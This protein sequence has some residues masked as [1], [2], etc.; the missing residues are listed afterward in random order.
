MRI[1]KKESGLIFHQKLREVAMISSIG[2]SSVR[3]NA[4]SSNPDLQAKICLGVG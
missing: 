2:K 3:N 4:F 1:L